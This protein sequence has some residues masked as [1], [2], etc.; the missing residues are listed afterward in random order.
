M[1]FPFENGIKLRRRVLWIKKLKNLNSK[2]KIEIKTKIQLS[3]KCEVLYL[4]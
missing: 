3:T 2:K 4:S 1:I